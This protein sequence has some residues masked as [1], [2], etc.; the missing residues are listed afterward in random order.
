MYRVNVTDYSATPGWVAYQ[1]AAF[2]HAEKAFNDAVKEQKALIYLLAWEITKRP[3]KA[4]GGKWVTVK[5]F[6]HYR[7]LGVDGIPAR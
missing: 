5:L 1:G 7:K 2:S 6:R 3:G 4:D